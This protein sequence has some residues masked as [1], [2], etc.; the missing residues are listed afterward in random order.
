MYKALLTIVLQKNEWSRE[1]EKN[2]L[3]HKI[4]QIQSSN[5]FTVPSVDVVGLD[6]V[7]VPL[8][9]FVV[10]QQLFTP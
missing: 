7:V 2:S 3:D 1:L 8:P 9:L 4:S 5:Y 10:L 6:G